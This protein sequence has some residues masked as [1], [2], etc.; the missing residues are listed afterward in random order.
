M[1]HP[2]EPVLTG[3]LG[4]VRET[5]RAHGWAV[6]GTPAEFGVPPI[7]YTV[8]L[9]EHRLPELLLTGIDPGPAADAL[10]EVAIRLRAGV[11]I[12]GR[13]FELVVAAVPRR[14]HLQINDGSLL[15]V[16]IALYGAGGFAAAELVLG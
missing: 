16:P 11:V 8:G 9:T 14:V 13:R 1:G 6:Q 15:A 4:Q 7:A 10:N 3:Y 5:I 12:V 2:H